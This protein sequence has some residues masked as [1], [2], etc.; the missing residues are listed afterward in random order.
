MGIKRNA[1]KKKKFG[2]RKAYAVNA[3]LSAYLR[4]SRRCSAGVKR[5]RGAREGT[6]AGTVLREAP[7]EV[8]PIVLTA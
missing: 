5:Q 7:E 1:T 6:P 2:A 3:R 4:A 8:L